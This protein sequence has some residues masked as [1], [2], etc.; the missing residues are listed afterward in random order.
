MIEINIGAS[1]TGE[2]LVEELYYEDE[3]SVIELIKALDSRI[4]DVDFT[5]KLIEE[6]VKSLKREG[7]NAK[8]KIKESVDG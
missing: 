2:A 3:A 4:G 6:L 5:T 8:F 7:V 1:I